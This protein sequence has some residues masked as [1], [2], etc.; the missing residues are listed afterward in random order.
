MGRKSIVETEQGYNVTITGRHV[1]VTDAMKEYAIDKIVK[2][3]RVVDRIID[4]TVT[5]DIQKLDHKIDVIFRFDHFKIRAQAVSDNMYTSID[6]VA[7]KLQSQLR[8]YKSKIK[9]HQAKG[10]AV[11]DMNVNI[12]SKPMYDV[13]LEELNDEIDDENLREL[14]A[15]YKL[16]KIVKKETR[17]L[18]ILTAEE[19]IMKL[20]L[21][22]D[23]FL[24]F[25]EESDRQIKIIYRRDDGNYGVIEP[26]ND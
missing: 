16:S 24:V 22:N 23:V 14:E 9:D 6:R 13:D 26:G 18:K 1:E 19:A 10:L 7:E 2:I 8:K 12:Y 5:M 15:S 21:S 3:E 4:V 25:R 20:E 11:V 17:P